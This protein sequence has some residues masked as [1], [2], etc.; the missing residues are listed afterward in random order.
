M[1]KLVKHVENAGIIKVDMPAEVYEEFKKNLFT[2]LRKFGSSR[3]T[4]AVHKLIDKN[5]VYPAIFMGDAS[6]SLVA[7]VSKGQ[8]LN[9]IFLNTYHFDDSLMGDGSVKLATEL[10][11]IEK[12]IKKEETFVNEARLHNIERLQAKRKEVFEKFLKSLDYIKMIDGIYFGFLLTLSVNAIVS[13]GPSKAKIVTVAAEILASILKKLYLS[14]NNNIESE[15]HQLLEAIAYY[16][17]EIYYYGLSASYA[18]NK[19]KKAFNEEILDTILKSKIT[20]F[21]KFNDLAGLLRAT[22]VLPITDA[23]FELQMKKMFGKQ[24]Y[25]VYIDPAF[26]SYTAFMANMAQPNQ[27]FKD[28]YPINEELHERLEELILNEQKKITFKDHE[29]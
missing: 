11:K 5:M 17:I 16:F 10:L 21:K 18:L 25:D 23:T 28:S 6:D 8:Q 22:E 19:L 26:T 12:D 2:V 24:A 1:K 15:T 20:Q 7:P 29:I 13:E 9:G 3:K 14:V 27:L 4:R